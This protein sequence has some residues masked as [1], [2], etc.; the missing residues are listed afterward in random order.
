MLQNAPPEDVVGGLAGLGSKTAFQALSG[1]AM[2]WWER[3]A[4]VSLENPIV[5]LSFPMGA[6]TTSAEAEVCCL[7]RKVFSKQPASVPKPPGWK[8]PAL[9]PLVSVNRKATATRAVPG[10]MQYAFEDHHSVH[11]DWVPLRD[12]CPAVVNEMLDRL[13][14]ARQTR[15]DP[16]SLELALSSTHQRGIKKLGAL[17]VKRLLMQVVREQTPSGPGDYRLKMKKL[18]FLSFPSHGA[19]EL[20][21]TH[22]TEE[23]LRHRC[24]EP[25]NW[26][27][28]E[29]N[30]YRRLASIRSA[31]HAR[32]AWAIAQ[33]LWLTPRQRNG[34]TE[35]VASFLRLGDEVCVGDASLFT[36][37][38]QLIALA[39]ISLGRPFLERVL[40]VVTDQ[41]T[42]SQLVNS[43]TIRAEVV[44]VVSPL[45]YEVRAPGPAPSISRAEYADA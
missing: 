2:K 45:S 12:H 28:F 37:Q 11:Y 42:I 29:D 31:I 3:L 8:T 34:R 30:L 21:I 43:E 18:D 32:D 6:N 10:L 40:A 39:T 5:R 4:R 24:L 20:R 41:A 25:L 36:A 33:E 1:G 17:P 44:S 23:F 22:L 13:P 14:D 35:W 38:G 16:R 9:P 27:G 15:S 26:C 19:S 7:G